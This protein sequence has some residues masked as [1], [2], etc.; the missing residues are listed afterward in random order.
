MI[1]YY[2][3][4]DLLSDGLGNFDD[5]GV[6]DNNMLNVGVGIVVYVEG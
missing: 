2:V 5:V 3:F 6:I 1:V 4:E